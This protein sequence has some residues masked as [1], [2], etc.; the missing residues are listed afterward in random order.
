[1]ST[2]RGVFR[3]LRLLFYTIVY[4]KPSQ[5]LARL[6]LK[7]KR[8]LLVHLPQWLQASLCAQTIEAHKVAQDLAGALFAPRKNLAKYSNGIYA[9]TFLNETRNF[10]VP[11]IWHDPELENGTRLWKL[12][13]HYMEF[14]ECLEDEQFIEAVNDWIENNLQ[15]RQGYW[16]DNWNSYAL[17]IRVVVWMQQYE[18]RRDRLPN[19]FKEKITVSLWQ[20]INFLEVNLETDILG[21]HIIKNIKALLWAARFFAERRSQK[22]HALALALLHIELKE[23]ILE[24]GFHFE[25]SPAYHNQVF[26]DLIECY[27]INPS[28]KVRDALDEPLT[29]MAQVTADMTHPDELP[30]LFN[31]G[32]L[33]MTYSPAQCLE[34]YMKV[35]GST[36]SPRVHVA[37]PAAGY[38]GLRHENNFILVDCAPIAPDYLMAHGHGDIFSFEWSVDGHRIVVDAGV[39]EY[40]TGAWRD[41]SR[42][43]RAHNTVT[44][45]GEDQ[46][47]FWSSFRVARR[48]RVKCI[49]YQNTKDGFL[50][51]GSHDGYQRL[52]GHPIHRRKFVVAPHVVI[53]E[54]VV[55]G[56]NQQPV[57]A[58]ILL[59]P[60]C[61]VE[62]NG[63]CAVVKRERVSVRFTSESKCELTT[64]WFCPD[65]GVANEAPCL[66]FRYGKAPVAG[67][68][69]IEVLK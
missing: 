4:T 46:C 58:R 15:Y 49:E 67:S 28:G 30:S 37:F 62:I 64:A 33:H 29:R 18:A 36:I 47:E 3:Q 66:V 22:W 60:S 69:T 14:L 31:D 26:A 27:A 59:H 42:S 40:N 68:I 48:A 55:Q 41:Y 54:D 35:T 23:Q 8:Y 1:M 50:L 45:D 16:L 2:N 20:Q 53:I 39:F 10:S 32:G 44:V 52:K 38:Y 51:T 9:L 56:G 57:E 21:N 17:S 34:A 63:R 13:L 25:R 6:R 24:D 43:T 61:K 11:F 65:F 19:W 12:N 5:L 7:L